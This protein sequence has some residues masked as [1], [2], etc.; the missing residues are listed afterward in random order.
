M[1]IVYVATLEHRNTS[2]PNARIESEYLPEVLEVLVL[3]GLSE[4]PSIEK[5]LDHLYI[6][7]AAYSTGQFIITIKYSEDEKR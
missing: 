3:L 2:L 7:K 5:V 6:Q 1:K 4:V